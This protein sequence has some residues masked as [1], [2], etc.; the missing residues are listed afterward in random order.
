M[1]LFNYGSAFHLFS[2]DANAL[3]SSLERAV[4]EGSLVKTKYS[5]GSLV[6]VGLVVSDILVGLLVY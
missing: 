5:T 1:R 2:D 4:K 6:C 3:R